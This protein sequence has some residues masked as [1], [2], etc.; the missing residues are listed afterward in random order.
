MILFVMVLLV[1]LMGMTWLLVPLFGVEAA[2]ATGTFAAALTSTPVM[3][4]VVDML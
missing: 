2:T 3:A 4:A 1:G